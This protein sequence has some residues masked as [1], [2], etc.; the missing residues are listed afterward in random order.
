MAFDAR[1]LSLLPLCFWAC[2][3]AEDE[4]EEE[5]DAWEYFSPTHPPAPLPLFSSC[6]QIQQTLSFY[7]P[8][9]LNH[10]NPPHSLRWEPGISALYNGD[11]IFYSYR[12]GKAY[13]QARCMLDVSHPVA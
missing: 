3:A 6:T 4:E 2:G 1:D 12:L 13:I 5:E 11:G 9:N 7:G 10:S 8:L